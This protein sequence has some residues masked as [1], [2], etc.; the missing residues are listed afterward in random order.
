MRA[1]TS[2]L[3]VRRFL[4]MVNQLNKFAS[5]IAET[6]KLLRDFLSHQN[7]WNWEE[8]QSAFNDVKKTLV[9]SQVLAVFDHGLET[10]VSADASSYK[11][12]VL[13][14]TQKGSE[15]CPGASISRAITPSEQ[16]Y[17]QI[18]KEVLA[19]TFL[20]GDRPQTPGSSFLQQ[21]PQ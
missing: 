8:Q 1:P 5:N 2:A 20:C 3:Q 10:T 18:E 14:Q 9:N 19:L 17:A 21:D 15:I 13:L 6:T 12:G 4:R 16:R 11:R 7:Q